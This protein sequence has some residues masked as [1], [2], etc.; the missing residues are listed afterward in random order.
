MGKDKTSWL[1][2]E[3]DNDTGDDLGLG[4][5]STGVFTESMQHSGDAPTHAYLGFG[6]NEAETQFVPSTDKTEIYHGGVAGKYSEKAE[7]DDMVDPIVGWFVVVQGPGIGQSVNLGSGMN[8]IGRDPDERV[9]LPFGDTLISSKDHVRVI[10]DDES[11]EFLIAP[12][13]GSNVTKIGTKIVAT[14]QP[15]ENYS[16]I[17][18]SKQ[19]HVRFVAFCNEDF[20]WSDVA[21]NTDQK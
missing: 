15:L 20:D 11:R 18:L 7:F 3:T 8:T 10:Y 14:P 13:S 9:A 12:G 17:R 19:T 6:E 2:D 4:D 5:E 21:E 1:F 16:L